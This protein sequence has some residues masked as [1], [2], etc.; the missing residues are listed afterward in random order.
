LNTSNEE[1]DWDIELIGEIRD[2][3]KNRFIE[4]NICSEGEFYPYIND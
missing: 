3:I 2:I 4:L 1:I